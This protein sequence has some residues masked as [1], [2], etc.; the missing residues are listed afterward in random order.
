MLFLY[1]RK[2]VLRNNT[3]NMRG[4]RMILSVAMEFESRK[5]EGSEYLFKTSRGIGRRGRMSGGSFYCIGYWRKPRFLPRQT[6][7]SELP[8][9]FVRKFCCQYLKDQFRCAQPG[10]QPLARLDIESCP[11]SCQ[12]SYFSI[13]R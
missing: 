13:I 4:K 5:Q 10:D 6:C 11:H 12:F 7:R 8:L 9:S 2:V 3:E 1:C